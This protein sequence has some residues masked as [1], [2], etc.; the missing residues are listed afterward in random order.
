M[1]CC[2]LPQRFLIPVPRIAEFG[3]AEAGFC[4]AFAGEKLLHQAFF[5]GLERLELLRLSRDQ[6]IERGQAICDFLLFGE[7]RYTCIKRMNIISI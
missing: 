7:F 3:E 4:F 2:H 1:E 6:I 5:M